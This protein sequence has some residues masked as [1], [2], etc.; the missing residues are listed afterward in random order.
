MQGKM[1][2]EQRARMPQVFKKGQ[3]GNPLGMTGPVARRIKSNAEKATNL[4]EK[5]LDTLASRIATI[6]VLAEREASG[7]MDVADQLKQQRILLL[8]N[9]DVNKL[10]TDSENRG[11]GAP[12]L[13][14]SLDDQ[15]ERRLEDMSDAELAAIAAGEDEATVDEQG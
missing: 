12:K 5:F 11:L 9:S 8:L 2:D 10:I 1:T 14:V 13:P 7:D 4:R 6:E 15:R 3:S